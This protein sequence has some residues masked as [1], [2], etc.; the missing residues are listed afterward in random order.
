MDEDTGLTYKDA[1]D[2]VLS[3]ECCQIIAIVKVKANSDE[4]V[5]LE[6]DQS[7]GTPKIK[8][9]VHAEEDHIILIDC[10]VHISVVYGQRF[11]R[12]MCHN[13]D[14]EVVLYNAREP[15]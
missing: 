8:T 6:A 12:H 3:Y 10:Q 2:S 15:I 1:G 9:V 5:V 4:V 7:K 11:V 13:I 14:Q